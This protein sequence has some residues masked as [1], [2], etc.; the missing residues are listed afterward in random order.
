MYHFPFYPDVTTADDIFCH[1]QKKTPEEDS[2]EEDA[3]FRSKPGHFQS[4]GQ[5]FDDD[6]EVK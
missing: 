4:A 2:D 5:L 3:L 1:V 6:N